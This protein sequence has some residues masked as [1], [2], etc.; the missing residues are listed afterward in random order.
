VLEDTGDGT[1][2]RLLRSF[3]SAVGAVPSGRV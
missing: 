1:A 2:V 3:V